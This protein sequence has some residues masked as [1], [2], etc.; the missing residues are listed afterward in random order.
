M[1]AIVKTYNLR[2]KHGLI[3]NAYPKITKEQIHNIKYL[4][5][6]NLTEKNKLDEETARRA[7]QDLILK[8]KKSQIDS[9]HHVHGSQEGI[10]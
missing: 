8:G 7:K 2:A 4:C 9:V 6:R 5:L 3:A 10:T 1:S